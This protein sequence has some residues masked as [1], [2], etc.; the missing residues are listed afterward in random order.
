MAVEIIAPEIQLVKTIDDGAGTD[1]GG[2]DVTLGT[3]LWY[4]V[5]FQNIGTDNALNTIIYD[6]LPKNVN[7]LS[8]ASGDFEVDLPTGVTVLSYEEPSDANDN[9]GILTLSVDDDLVR[10]ITEGGGGLYN[11]RFKVQIAT[12]CNQ[13]V[14]ICS[15]VIENTAYATYVGERGGAVIENQPSFS[16]IDCLLYTSDAADE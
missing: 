3:E 12:D 4:N 5:S 9:Q 10:E 6:V 15:N 14:D 8:D 11:I 7:L 2:T 13:L 1:L 16:G